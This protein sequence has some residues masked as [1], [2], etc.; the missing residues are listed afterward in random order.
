[1]TRKELRALARRMRSGEDCRQEISDGLRGIIDP[2]T[3]DAMRRHYINGD[4]WLCVASVQGRSV[5]A[6]I[7]GVQRALK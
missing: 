2:M 6:V 3:R 7:K 5:D 1:M 4:S